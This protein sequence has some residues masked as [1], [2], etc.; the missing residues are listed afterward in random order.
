MKIRDKTQ[1]KQRIQNRQDE[2]EH[3]EDH[4]DVGHLELALEKH[5]LKYTDST[6]TVAVWQDT[7]SF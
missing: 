7:Q 4:N 5:W 1:L 2:E 6:Y 3:C